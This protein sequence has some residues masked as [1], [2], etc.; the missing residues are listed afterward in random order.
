M[1]NFTS[2]ITLYKNIPITPNQSK[3]FFFRASYNTVESQKNFFDLIGSPKTF[4]NL[5][6]IRETEINLEIDFDDILSYNYLTYLNKKGKRIFAFIV[7][8]KYISDNVSKIIIEIDYFQTYHF[9]F[10][11]LPSY[12][13]RE[14]QDRWQLHSAGSSYIIPKLS[15]T[16]ENIELGEDLNKVSETNLSFARNNPFN[17]AVLLITTKPYNDNIP[18]NAVRKFFFRDSNNRIFSTPF[19]VYLSFSGDSIDNGLKYRV[20]N[21]KKDGSSYPSTTSNVEI[22][23][24]SL[25]DL[26]DD[27]MVAYIPI[28][29]IPA[30]IVQYIDPNISYNYDL[31]SAIGIDF[32]AYQY[33]TEEHNK[34][35]YLLTIAS[36]TAKTTIRKSFFDILNVYSKQKP[37][38]NSLSVVHNKL[39]ETK[40]IN[41]EFQKINIQSNYM[42]SKQLKPE[43]FDW[44]KDEINFTYDFIPSLDFREWI[45]FE[46]YLEPN[47]DLIVAE[48][49]TLPLNSSAYMNYMRTTKSQRESGLLVESSQLASRTIMNV[50]SQNYAAALMDV[51][52][53]AGNRVMENAKMNDLK[54]I[55]D[56]IRSSGGNVSFM[57]QRNE[58]NYKLITSRP[59]DYF[60]NN[61]YNY[62]RL[63][64]YKSG[65]IDIPNL[66]SRY[67]YNY[68]ETRNAN[69]LPKND[70][71]GTA[72]EKLKI[73]FDKGI[74]LFH[75]RNTTDWNT[76]LK[77]TNRLKQQYENWELSLI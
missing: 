24:A 72:I 6:W 13:E 19:Y 48:E 58:F 55:P 16:K 8:K 4:S 27:S 33:G 69:L 74:T 38:T 36:M 76:E 47:S 21:T 3:S 5:K 2:Q 56:S 60:L 49:R 22:I 46:N 10:D 41:S 43:L 39:N 12:I 29:S 57:I 1:S 71:D 42:N 77:R 34:N 9:D 51:Q 70:I 15:S 37:T 59:N 66:I 40:L 20:R 63:Y 31:D 67:H 68:I 17:S 64:G 32:R 35:W 7:D 28:Q 45:Q 65:T 75:I 26:P 25:P 62:M 61:A 73:I 18:S 11:F 23:S 44:T 52:R 50:A 54:T 14:H 53:F 30:D